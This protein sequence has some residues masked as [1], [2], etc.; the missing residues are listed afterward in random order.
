LIAFASRQEKRAQILVRKWNEKKKNKKLG[1]C[2][3]TAR[4]ATSVEIIVI[5]AVFD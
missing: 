3:E 5:M 4:C 1:Y 2:R